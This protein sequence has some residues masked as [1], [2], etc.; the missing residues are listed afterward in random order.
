M[1]FSCATVAPFFNFNSLLIPSLLHTPTP[2][3]AQKTQGPSPCCSVCIEDSIV[4]PPRKI[5]S[6]GL[7]WSQA[8][9]KRIKIPFSWTKAAS[10]V[11]PISFRLLSTFAVYWRRTRDAQKI[12]KGLPFPLLRLLS[13]L[14][15]SLRTISDCLILPGE[16]STNFHPSQHLS[17]SVFIF[18][19]FGSLHDRQF[20]LAS[21]EHGA[22]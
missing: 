6:F 15:R 1:Y 12:T 4:V 22:S 3:V 5:I 19:S 14:I 10:R 16:K 2:F 17:S 21:Q 13:N 9:Q 18:C 8:S 11:P 20:S 7:C